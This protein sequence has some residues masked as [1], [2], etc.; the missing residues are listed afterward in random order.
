M[1]RISIVIGITISLAIVSGSLSMLIIGYRCYSG[2]ISLSDNN[3][4]CENIYISGLIM[5]FLIGCVFMF[6]LLFKLVDCL[7]SV[8]VVQVK[9]P[10]RR[11]SVPITSV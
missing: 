1:E 11:R 10:V 3:R 6:Y 4:G 2:Y 7:D 8:N 9:N 5:T